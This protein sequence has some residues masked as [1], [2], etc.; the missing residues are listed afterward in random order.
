MSETKIQWADVVWNPTRGC[1]VVSPGCHFCYAMKQAHRFD[2]PGGAYDGLTKMTSQGAQWT[3]LVTLAEDKLTEPL[4]WRKPRRIFVDSMSDLFHDG[5]PD[6]YIDRV[7][8]IMALAQHHTFQVLTKRP[9]RMRAYLTA[10]VRV[11]QKTLAGSSVPAGGAFWPEGSAATRIIAAIDRIDRDLGREPHYP[12]LPHWPLPNV[13]LGVSVEDQQHADERIS[14]LLDT[15]AAVRFISA[16]PL[17]GPIA[18]WERWIDRHQFA[19]AGTPPGFID[20]VICGG[21]SGP[22]ARPFDIAWARSLRDQC[23]AAGTAFFLKQVGRRPAETQPALGGQ[24]GRTAY[25]LDLRDS[26]GGDESEWPD[27][28]RG[29]RAFP[30]GGSREP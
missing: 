20:W 10:G 17:L 24:I 30:E 1:S 27:D 18:L 15:P 28:L 29:C 19:D 12:R 26:H 25:P 13:W 5:V 14:L 11:Y 3:G 16:E 2:R 8:A 7:F 21:E 4:R 23:A 22:K 6:S 9:E